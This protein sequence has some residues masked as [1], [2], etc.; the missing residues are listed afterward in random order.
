MRRA[1]RPLRAPLPG[2]LPAPPPT[3]DDSA[4]AALPPSAEAD[5][6]QPQPQPTDAAEPVA[7]DPAVS[8]ALACGFIS[9]SRG[10]ARSKRSTLGGGLEGE[11]TGGHW[12]SLEVGLEITGGTPDQMAAFAKAEVGRIAELV[13]V[14]GI[15]LMD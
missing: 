9:S 8:G 11:I 5:I 13:K 7:A 10:R 3:D 15:P 12:R 4:T 14:A 2:A 6:A 1:G